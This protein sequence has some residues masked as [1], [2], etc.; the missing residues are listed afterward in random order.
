M[1]KLINS[2]NLRKGLIKKNMH[3]HTLWGKIQL[4]N[5]MLK[6]ITNREG[7]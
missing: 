4:L 2:I 6:T 7:M 1:I 3:T 5:P